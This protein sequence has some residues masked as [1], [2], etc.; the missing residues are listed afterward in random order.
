[1]KY[2]SLSEKLILLFISLVLVIV[3]LSGLIFSFLKFPLSLQL[4]AIATIMF[5][6]SSVNI[7]IYFFFIKTVINPL[8]KISQVANR[9][10]LGE[11]GEDFSYRGNDEFRELVIS[12][13]RMKLSLEMALERN[14]QLART[15]KQNKIS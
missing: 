10:S 12:L 11:R 5:A 7:F 9:V 6:L 15:I 8:N 3:P 13:N 1:M 4:Q 2:S 14:K